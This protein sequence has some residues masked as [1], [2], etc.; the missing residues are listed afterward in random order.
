MKLRV[1]PVLKQYYLLHNAVPENMAVGFAAYIYFMKAVKEEHGKYYGILNGSYYPVNDAKAPWFYEK[2]Q[3]TPLALIAASVLGEVTLWDFDL[4]SLPGFAEAVQ[5][6]L[7]EI[8]ETGM[9]AVLDP[10]Q[11]KKSIA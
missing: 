8:D 5:E 3:G 11:S 6:K 10:L 4:N 7:N 2:W 1:V 9:S